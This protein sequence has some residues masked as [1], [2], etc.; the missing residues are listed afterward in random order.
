M[1]EHGDMFGGPRRLRKNASRACG[2]SCRHGDDARTKAASTSV[3]DDPPHRFLVG[4][5]YESNRRGKFTVVKIEGDQMV[6]RWG[7]GEIAPVSAQQQEKILRN[8]EHEVWE[9]L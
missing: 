6:I 4:E 9:R 5:S 2:N 3:P 7:N 8:Y 1:H